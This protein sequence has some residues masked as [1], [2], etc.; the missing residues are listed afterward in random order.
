MEGDIHMV[1]RRRYDGDVTDHQG[2]AMKTGLIVLPL[3]LLASAG[4]AQEAGSQADPAVAP[5]AQA[6]AA[7]ADAVKSKRRQGIDRRQCLEL[8]DNRA[9]IRCAESGRKR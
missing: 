1:R 6:A 5:S 4:M 3:A 7:P 2:T 9:I 8:K